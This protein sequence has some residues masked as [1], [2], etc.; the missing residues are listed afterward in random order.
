MRGI[1]LI[2]EP[3]SGKSSIAQALCLLRPLEHLK[4]ERRSFAGPLKDEVA[5]AIASTE[6]EEWHSARG[7]TTEQIIRRLMDDPDRK[8]LFRPI[9][10]WWGTE[11][12]RGQDEN[13]W[14]KKFEKS[15]NFGATGGFYIVDDLRFNNEYD[16]LKKYD[17]TVVLL[18]SGQT[19]RPVQAHASEVDWKTWT[20]D[21][22]L[23]YEPGPAHQALR[24]VEALE[25]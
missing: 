10:Q 4:P 21:Y 16:L 20:P 17:F 6:E 1:A 23:S 25:L 15:I 3:G 11:F 8:D 24:L 14:L 22:V 7:E 19:T 5:H 18:E 13:Y 9:L 12:R 2:G